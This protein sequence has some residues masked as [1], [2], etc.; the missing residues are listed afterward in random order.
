MKIIKYF[1]E[2]LFIIILFVI[3]KF[4]GFKLASNLGSFMGGLLG[5]SFRSKKKN[6]IK[7]KKSFT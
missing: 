7:Y 2:F 1:V 4:L 5:P 3:F 6:N